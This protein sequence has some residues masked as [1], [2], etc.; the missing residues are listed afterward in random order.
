MTRRAFDSGTGDAGGATSVP[1]TPRQNGSFAAGAILGAMVEIGALV[2]TAC[3]A[4]LAAVA[5][6]PAVVECGFCGAV[7]SVAHDAQTITRP[8]TT[9]D[10][11]ELRAAQRQAAK[12]K[13]VAELGRMLAA[14]KHPYDAVRDAWALHLSFEAI[15]EPVARLTVALAR[16]FEREQGASAT[17]AT[18]LPRIADA[19]L[20]AIAELRFAKSTEMNLP[21]LTAN[22]SGPKHMSSVVTPQLFAELARRDPYETSP[23]GPPAAPK[24]D[25]TTDPRKRKKLFGLF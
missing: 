7:M 17:D 20:K 15:A 21:F 23:L 19:Y 16:D 18:A 5:S 1:T 4:P 9:S 25:P 13:F 22:E 6:L 2:C 11:I 8:A 3:G 14:G 12:P 10:E 24:P